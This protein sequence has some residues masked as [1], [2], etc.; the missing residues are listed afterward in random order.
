MKLRTVIARWFAVLP[1]LGVVG[2]PCCGQ[3]DAAA[4]SAA[5]Q[6]QEKLE[7]VRLDVS[8]MFC[9]GCAVATRAALQKLAGVKKVEVSLKDRSAVVTYEPSKVN[10]AQMLEAIRRVGFD[11]KLAG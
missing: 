2:I 9:G 11:A 6:S 7:T 8:G 3:S 1:L 4:V 5:P 10:H